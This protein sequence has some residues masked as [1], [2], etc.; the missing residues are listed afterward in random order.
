M[1]RAGTSIA[2]AIRYCVI[3]IGSRNSV[4]RISPGWVGAKSAMGRL[5]SSGSQRFLVVVNE[6]DIR[7][8]AGAPRE[9]EAPLVVHAHAVLAS[10][11]TSQFL[12][13]VSRRHA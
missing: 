4:M 13:A 8:T 3:P 10:A 9:A 11:I 5:L 2:L 6:F 7:G 12:E 1:R